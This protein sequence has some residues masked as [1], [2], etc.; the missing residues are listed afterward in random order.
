MTSPVNTKNVTYPSTLTAPKDQN[1][2]SL[3][4]NPNLNTHYIFSIPETPQPSQ[5][6]PRKNG[7]FAHEEK[8]ICDK[9]YYC[10]DGKFNMI[11]CPAGLVYNEK[12]GICTWPDEAKKKGCSSEGTKASTPKISYNCGL[13]FQR[14]SILS[15]QK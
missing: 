15:V 5:H 6:C 10:V 3:F 8:N 4:Q 2:V 1:S 12:T 9:F 14:S 7:Y 13:F 11:T